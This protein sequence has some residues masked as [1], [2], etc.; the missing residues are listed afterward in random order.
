VFKGE[1]YFAITPTSEDTVIFHH[2][3][4][5]TGFLLPLVLPLLRKDGPQIY[6]ALDRALKRRVGGPL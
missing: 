1:H 4:I 5:F 6:Q 2:G 3:E